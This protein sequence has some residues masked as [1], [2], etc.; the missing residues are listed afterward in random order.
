MRK[1]IN[2]YIPDKM[3]NDIILFTY[4]KIYISLV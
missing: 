4:K 2:S 3:Q 1:N